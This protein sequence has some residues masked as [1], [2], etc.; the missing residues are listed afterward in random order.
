M[1]NR[2]GYRLTRSVLPDSFRHDAEDG[3]HL[4]HDLTIV[5][6]IPAA[7]DGIS[8][9]FSSRRKKLPMRSKSLKSASPLSRTAVTVC[10]VREQ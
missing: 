8:M 2:W 4:H 9:Y 10:R 1:V 7:I 3:K 6:V 5:S